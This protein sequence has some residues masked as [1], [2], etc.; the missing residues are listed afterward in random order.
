MEALLNIL[1]ANP[2][3]AIW[4]IV[5]IIKKLVKIAVTLAIIII[6]LAIVLHYFGHD[7]LPQE[8][9]EVLEKAEEIIS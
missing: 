8:G 7:T 5:T 9:R 1:L 2:I 3:L 6:A 4:L